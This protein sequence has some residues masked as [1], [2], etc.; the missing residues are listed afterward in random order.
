VDRVAAARTAINVSRFR[1]LSTLRVL[2][3]MRVLAFSDLHRDRAAARRIVERSADADVVIG[4]GD[5]ASWRLGL[6]GII[7]ELRPI[8]RPTILVPGNNETDTALWR[9]CAGWESAS[10]LHGDG[11]TI[12]GVEFFGVG[13]GVPP[14]PLPWSFDLSEDDAARR[15]ESCPHGAVLIVHSPP[16]GHVDRAF[17]KSLGS[18][19]VLRAIEEKRPPLVLCGHVH[20]CQG[21]ESFVGGSRVVNLGPE[22]M[23]FEV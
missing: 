17:G 13:A 11:I 9:A 5:F 12:G 10:V 22:G 3:D 20:Q 15:L 6:T 21:R 19:A 18:S 7:D 16:K 4:A 2:Q 14:T 23:W 8:A 1:N